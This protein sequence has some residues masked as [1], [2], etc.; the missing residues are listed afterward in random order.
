MIYNFVLIYCVYDWC[1]GKYIGND[2][3]IGFVGMIIIFVM[4]FGGYM[5]VGGKMGIIMKVLLFE[6]IMI[7]GVVFGVFVLFNDMLLIKYIFKDI[8]KVFKG[9][10]WK[11]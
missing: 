1:K 3:M 6:M 11:Y 5:F 7:G 4:V 8:G 9:I 10:K 2:F